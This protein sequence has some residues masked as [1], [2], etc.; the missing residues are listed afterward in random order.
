MFE[1]CWQSA[2]RNETRCWTQASETLGIA[3]KGLISDAIL[4]QAVAAKL[5]CGYFLKVQEAKCKSLML[6]GHKN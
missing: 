3:E 4:H 1:K 5:H 6:K 2:K